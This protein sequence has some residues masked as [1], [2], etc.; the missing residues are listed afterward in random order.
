MIIAAEY[1]CNNGA[2][3]L[4]AKWQRELDEV[5]QSILRVDAALCRTKISRE[6]TMSGRRFNDPKALHREFKEAFGS[7]G[8]DCLKLE[9]HYSD[10]SDRPGYTKRP[11]ARGAFREMDF[12]K[13]KLGVQVPF[14]KY[15][16]M[17]SPSA[18]R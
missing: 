15:A 17:V 12:S 16:F 7:P 18:P 1:S 4:A 5:Y 14:G 11:R 6:K 3:T 9:C 2:T 10:A 13:N 8:W